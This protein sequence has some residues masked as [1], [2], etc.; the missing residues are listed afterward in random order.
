MMRRKLAR[1]SRRLAHVDIYIETNCAQ[2]PASSLYDVG[3]DMTLDLLRAVIHVF[4]HDIV[5]H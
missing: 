5:L 3:K 1:V 4:G 2:V